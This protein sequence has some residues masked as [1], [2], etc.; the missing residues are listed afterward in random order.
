MAPAQ[1]TIPTELLPRDGR[2]GSG[3]SKVRSAH[4]AGLAAVASTV[5]GTS[6]RQPPV[7]ELISRLQRGM[8][9]LLAAP[10]GYEVVLGLGGATAFWDAACFSL[11][12]ERAAHGVFGE[13]GAKFAAAT[14]AAPFLA[15]SL[16]TEAEPGGLALPAMSGGAD[17]YAW[18]HNETSTGV[19]AP[20]QRLGDD[21]EALMLIDATSAA[22]ALDIDVG[23]S[24]VYYFSPQK[25]FGADGGLWVALMSPAA[26]ARIEEL[27]ASRWV[28]PFLS[29]AAAV[30]SSR[31]QQTINTPALATLYLIVEQLDWLLDAGGLSWASERSA[32]SARI[33]YDWAENRPWATPFVTDAAQ[34][35]PVVGTID[36]SADVDA[37]RV[38]S[39]LRENGVLDV[40][41]YRGLGRNQ[42]RV[43]MFPAVAPSD[44]EALTTCI[45]YVVARLD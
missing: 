26:L 17:V 12:R 44:V 5:V 6:H 28:P 11:V 37:A 14:N 1:L 19:R 7:R 2:F 15:E 45:D 25:V 34:R 20:V 30:D 9:E 33:L 42:L 10:D 38:A 31:K 41:P 32:T 13:F 22:G 35:S 43:G 21:P 29:L 3:P 27:A 24:D 23:A 16:I 40:E 36:L 8:A 4:I 39:V 18:P